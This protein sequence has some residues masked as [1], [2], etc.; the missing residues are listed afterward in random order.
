MTLTGRSASAYSAEAQMLYDFR[1]PGDTSSL[2]RRIF[3]CSNAIPAQP[4]SL[5]DVRGQ[6]DE[7]CEYFQTGTSLPGPEKLSALCEVS[8]DD[9]VK[10]IPHLKNHTFWPVTDDI[11]VHSGM[12]EHL[13]SIADEFKI[14]GYKMLIGEMRNEETLYSS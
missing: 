12:L 13:Q 2:C 5:V 14:R 8:S 4:K 1:K 11:F 3:M 7:L 9:L 6:F 10:G